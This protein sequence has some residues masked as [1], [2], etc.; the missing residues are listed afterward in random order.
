MF[1]EYDTNE[2]FT[3][4]KAD[5][6]INENHQKAGPKGT[7][8]LIDQASLKKI[9]HY[10]QM[11]V[12]DEDRQFKKYKILFYVEFLEFICRVALHLADDEDSDK[13]K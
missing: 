13:E 3:L 11:V 9:F 7:P 4:E 2:G 10:S 8:E 6:L 12:I 1:R 5:K